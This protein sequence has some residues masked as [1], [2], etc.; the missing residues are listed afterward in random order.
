MNECENWENRLAAARSASDALVELYESK[1]REDINF[2]L[3][4]ICA[5]SGIPSRGYLLSVMKKR[6][7]LNLKYRD[8]ISKGFGLRGTS[9]KFLKTLIDIEHEKDANKLSRLNRRLELYRKSL[10]YSRP[11]V[12]GV[13]PAIPMAV[14]VF[15][16]FGLFNNRA[17]EEDIINYFGAKDA[18]AVVRALDAL[19]DQDLIRVDGLHYKVVR[20]NIMFSGSQ[21]GLT[22]IDFLKQGMTQARK[23]VNKWFSH[24][25]LSHFEGSILSIRK[26]HLKF[27]LPNF[28]SQ[29]NETRSR[30]ETS[31]G[32]M[33]IHFSVQLFPLGRY[34]V[35]QNP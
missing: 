12:P 28:K 32:N 8:T 20:D 23:A 15:A 27:L 33:L 2:S 34:S 10:A 22:H 19:L 7:T 21:E 1:K 24:P 4:E 9:S 31:S 35:K 25:E 3:A 6:R 16:A 11:L 17:M 13:L 30:M 26:E 5:K 18:R 14:E 29:L